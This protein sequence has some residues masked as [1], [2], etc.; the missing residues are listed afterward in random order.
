MGFG[1]PFTRRGCINSPPLQNRPRNLRGPQ[2]GAPQRPWCPGAWRNPEAFFPWGTLARTQWL[3]SYWD[4][5]QVCDRKRGKGW[6]GQ[7]PGGG[8]AQD[9]C[10]SKAHMYECAKYM[11]FGVSQ[12]HVRQL[13]VGV[14]V[15]VHPSALVCWG[16]RV[17]WAWHR[18]EGL[19]RASWEHS[20]QG[21]QGFGLR[22][23]GG[24]SCVTQAGE[25]SYGPLS[26]E[27]RRT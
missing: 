27:T 17:C 20:E 19:Q 4:S 16:V 14:G 8:T 26:P 25:A 24:A 10:A 15:C 23:C 2:M 18:K 13:C 6:K 11:N 5:A 7:Q 3:G 22:G 12:A 1:A 9:P 21:Q